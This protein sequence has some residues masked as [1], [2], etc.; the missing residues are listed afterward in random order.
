MPAW[1]Y[2]AFYGDPADGLGA[3][4]MH[5]SMTGGTAGLVAVG[6]PLRITGVALVWTEHPGWL[7]LWRR[8]RLVRLRDLSLVGPDVRF[9]ELDELL[10]AGEA[11]AGR[12]WITGGSGPYPLRITLQ[13]QEV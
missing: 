6:R 12:R 11:L 9:D 7:E 8:N 13:Y 2:R 5:D 3:H 1:R 10:E 4:A